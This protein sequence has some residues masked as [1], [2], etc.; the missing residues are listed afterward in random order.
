VREI[1][2]HPKVHES[3]DIEFKDPDPE[4]VRRMLCDEHDFSRDR[5]DTA[6]EK[7]VDARSSQKQKSLDRWFGSG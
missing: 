4:G 7:F 1:F 5:I 6:L 3:V 2:L